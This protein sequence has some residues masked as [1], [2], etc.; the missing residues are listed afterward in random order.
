MQ[1]NFLE[2]SYYK[3]VLDRMSNIETIEGNI[4]LWASNIDDAADAL[5][6]RCGTI[7][8]DIEGLVSRCGTIETDI[9][10]L[11]SGK[12]DKFSG[13]TSQYVRGDGS[14][15][16]F[17]S[18]PASQV[19]SDWNANSG[20][21]QILNKPTIPA[22][23]Q[24]SDW[25]AA[26]GVTRILNKPA[27]PAAQ[28]NSDWNAS[29]GVAQVL[30]K[31]RKVFPFKATVSGGNAVF[32]LTTDGTAGGTAFFANGP[33]LDSM[34]LTAEEGTYPHA[35]GTPVLSNGNKTLTV[36]VNKFSGTYIAL[37]SLTL[38]GGSTAANGSVV[39]LMIAGAS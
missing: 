2:G 22:A 4:S 19:S 37:L 25:S 16:S 12:Q 8:T 10:S 13:T 31:P 33:D 6:S 7:E 35:F 18:I 32:Y 15:S 11:Q 36:P 27:I 24:P 29:T 30:N 17:P 20:V 26:S 38:L 14:L 21:A 3:E 39:R 5:V 1:M 9:S 23:Q 28:V 34:Q